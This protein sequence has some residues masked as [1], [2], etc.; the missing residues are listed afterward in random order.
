[1]IKSLEDL[2]KQ[3]A[4]R[5]Q[6]KEDFFVR[7]ENYKI[8]NLTSYATI[9]FIIMLLCALS[10]LVIFIVSGIK[11]NFNAAITITLSVLAFLTIFSLI[12]SIVLIFLKNSLK[13]KSGKLSSGLISFMILVVPLYLILLVCYIYVPQGKEIITS[14]FAAVTTISA[15]VL[16]MMGVHYTLVQQKNE[17]IDKNNLVFMLNEDSES[18]AEYEVKNALGDLQLQLKIK[19]ISNNLGYL[20]GLYKL[21]GCDVYQIGDEFP[22]LA[23]SPNTCFSI[24]DIRINNG[25]DQLILVYKDIGENYYYLL[26]AISGD[27][28]S[29]IKEAGKCDFE[30]LQDQ[31]IETDETEQAVNSL[32][33]SN[34]TIKIA[35]S[36]GDECDEEINISKRKEETKPNRT[37]NRGGFDLIV[38]EDGETTDFELL[39]ALRNQRLKLAKEKKIKAFMIFNNQQLVALATYKPYDEK[40]FISIYGL[41]KKKYDLYGD[42]FIQIIKNYEE[43]KCASLSA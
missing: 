17:R 18:R 42:L 39:T 2:K 32:N 11:Q 36:Q 21:C 41:G 37:V 24:T 29:E 15:A 27:K 10:A 6:E 13:F 34:K 25:D 4:L 1:M 3:I 14:F 26:L 5:K 38:S 19:N 9:S 16:A 12:C 28:I 40:S 23:I 43:R 8:S 20:I 35:T 31:I 30:F 22:Y 7:M 33:E